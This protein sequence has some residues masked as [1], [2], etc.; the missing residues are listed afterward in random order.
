MPPYAASL[1]QKHSGEPSGFDFLLTQLFTTRFPPLQ[2]LARRRFFYFWFFLQARETVFHDGLLKPGARLAAR[3]SVNRVGTRRLPSEDGLGGR[4]GPRSM[5]RASAHVRAPSG[6]FRGEAR[7]NEIL[8]CLS[9]FWN[10]APVS[11][12]S[13]MSALFERWMFLITF[14][15]A[16]ARAR[17]SVWNI[18]ASLCIFCTFCLSWCLRCVATTTVLCCCRGNLEDLVEHP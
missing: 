10:R 7:L 1:Q 3:L 12:P 2:V 4:G 8:L 16:R 14:G 5:Q 6:A 17:V 9:S 11:K 18:A 15:D 13:L